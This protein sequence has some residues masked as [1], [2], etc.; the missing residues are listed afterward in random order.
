MTDPLKWRHYEFEII[1]TCVRWYLRYAL[2]YRDLEEMMAECGLSV[3]HSTIF[4]WVQRYS[5]ELDRRCRPHLKQTNDSWR[6][7]ET[8]VKVRKGQIE[9]IEKGDIQGQTEFI[10]GL[11]G[12]AA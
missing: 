1:L 8:Y 6:V 3:D 7:D 12:L 5:P 9:G 2:S 11:F 4:C 10:L